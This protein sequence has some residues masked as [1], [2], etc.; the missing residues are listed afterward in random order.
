MSYF[1]NITKIALLAFFGLTTGMSV[2]A[3]DSDW[4]Y[5]L[6]PVLLHAG[7][8]KILMEDIKQGGISKEVWDKFIMSGEGNFDGFPDFRRGLYGVVPD[9]LSTV[10]L[11][12]DQQWQ[13]GVEN[14]LMA[15]HIKPECRQPN[16][17]VT[18]YFYLHEDLSIK[19]SFSHWFYGRGRKTKISEGAIKL[20]MK[21]GYDTYWEVGTYYGLNNA[22]AAT[23][24]Q[25][26]ICGG[27]VQSFL[28]ETDAKVVI[29][30]VNGDYADYSSWAIRDLNCI[31][32]ITGTPEDLFQGMFLG[33]M[34][35]GNITEFFGDWNKPYNRPSATFMLMVS[36]FGEAPGFLKA[37]W[38]KLSYRHFTE[39]SMQYI[40]G[41]L[42]RYTDK[43]HEIT[44]AQFEASAYHLL[45]YNTECAKKN[46]LV[47]LQALYRN[48]ADWFFMRKKACHAKDD[49][50]PICHWGK[51]PSYSVG[52]ELRPDLQDWDHVSSVLSLV[53][54]AKKLCTSK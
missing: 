47:K 28:Q 17:I 35:G 22:D 40:D 2:Q 34:N 1:K 36:I 15:I 44:H 6:P 26:E 39:T 52:E 37:N 10:S 19:D 3:D 12:G 24:K 23:K 38:K 30:P 46:R 5:T 31:E 49:T 50:D 42:A 9:D 11:Y 14:W 48:F 29:D 53:R 33:K 54:E 16:R 18:N 27:V 4:E 45:K 43:P 51:V 20:C 8:R 41:I 13:K 25:S 32:K 21:K 7:D